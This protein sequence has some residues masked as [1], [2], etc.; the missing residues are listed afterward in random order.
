MVKWTV[1]K[2]T[3]IECYLAADNC[4]ETRK[5]TEVAKLS[6]HLLRKCLP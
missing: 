6:F 2:A 4:M 5:N 3:L 1:V